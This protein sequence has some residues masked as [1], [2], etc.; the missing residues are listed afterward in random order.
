MGF[1][2][3]SL[4]AWVAIALRPFLASLGHLVVDTSDLV[5][6]LSSF[7]VGP[8]DMLVRLDIGKYDMCPDHVDLADAGSKSV[9]NSLHECIPSAIYFL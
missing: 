3:S 1:A 7:K 9:C 5:S 2:F 8:T 6:K 4:C